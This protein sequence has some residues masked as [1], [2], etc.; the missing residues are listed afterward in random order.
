MREWMERYSERLQNVF[1]DFICSEVEK[2]IKGLTDM[3]Y[4]HVFHL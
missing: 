4:G 1:S 3:V 2:E